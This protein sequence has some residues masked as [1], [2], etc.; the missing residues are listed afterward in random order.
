[1]DDAK[2]EPFTGQRSQSESLQAHAPHSETL[3]N[4]SE[5]SMHVTTVDDDMLWK[6][7]EHMLSPSSMLKQPQFYL[8]Q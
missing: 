6:M 5:L 8:I 7:S 1:M 2:L 3:L 4:C